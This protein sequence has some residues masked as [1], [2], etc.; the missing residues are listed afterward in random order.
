MPMR[1]VM[2]CKKIGEVGAVCGV[3]GA[4]MRVLQKCEKGLKRPDQSLAKKGANTSS[5]LHYQKKFLSR[6]RYHRAS[7]D[8]SILF[9]VR[10]EVKAGGGAPPA[11]GGPPRRETSAYRAGSDP[12]RVL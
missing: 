5:R 2:R 3:R 10:E 1:V 9:L 12:Q 7:W 8:G 11:R 6:Y 4:G